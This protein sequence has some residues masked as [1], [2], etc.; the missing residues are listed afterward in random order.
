MTTPRSTRLASRR[1]PRTVFGEAGN[2][3]FQR[4]SRAART[5]PWP[6]S[7]QPLNPPRSPEAASPEREPQLPVR[8][9]GV[10]L[11]FENARHHS[12]VA[13]P[14]FRALLLV[15][16]DSAAIRWTCALAASFRSTRGA[17]TTTASVRL[18]HSISAAQHLAPHLHPERRA[19]DE[20][21]G[22]RA[23]SDCLL[24]RSTVVSRR[25]RERGPRPTSTAPDRREPPTG[26]SHRPA[27]ANA[28]R[29]RQLP[30]S[31][32]RARAAH[33][34]PSAPASS[35]SGTMRHGASGGLR[36]RPGSSWRR[37]A[38]GPATGTRRGP[39]STP[40]ASA[41]RSPGP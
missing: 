32:T 26:A 33:R 15:R 22:R 14:R 9:L 5:S 24:G 7:A 37:S 31:P 3:T 29:V 17:S 20:R 6:R 2:P 25:S 10:Q 12:S 27:R 13:A 18:W 4:S 28:P 38:R 34:R 8:A 11:R 35:K 23:R 41:S 40:K 1:V 21:S 36:A 19:G 30:R 39:S 16:V